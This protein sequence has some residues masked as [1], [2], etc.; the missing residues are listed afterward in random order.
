MPKV[1]LHTLLFGLHILV[2]LLA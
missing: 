2:R 1:G